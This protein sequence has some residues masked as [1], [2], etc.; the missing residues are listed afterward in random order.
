MSISLLVTG[1]LRQNGA[2]RATG[3]RKPEQS[4]CKDQPSLFH[5]KP[6]LGTGH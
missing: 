4:G 5:S 3:V 1:D 6:D 2:G